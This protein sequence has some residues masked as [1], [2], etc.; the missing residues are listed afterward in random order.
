MHETAPYRIRAA[1]AEDLE[2]LPAIELAAAALFD[3]ADVGPATLAD[4]T[5]L[6]VL[7]EAQ[8]AG[9]LFVAE[10]DG[11]VIGFALADHLGGE[12]YLREIDVLPAFGR[13]GVGAAL[14]RAVAGWARAQGAASLALSTFRHVPWNAPFYA[15]L[16]FRPLETH[17]LT[18]A[19]H[20]LRAR[21]S[22]HGLSIERR[23]VMRLA[24]GRAA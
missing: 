22:A 23:V 17:E 21:E 10:L 8:R 2:S 11:A 15:R 7:A 16:G 18:A 9:R 1:R 5:P 6:A 19:H 20:A 14:V 12:P 3:P 4:T 13:R 24:L